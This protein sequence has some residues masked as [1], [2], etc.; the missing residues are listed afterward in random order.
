VTKEMKEFEEEQMV[1][2]LPTPPSG[3]TKAF[4]E[5]ASAQAIYANYEGSR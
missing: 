3:T 4:P 5:S 1:S 2:Y